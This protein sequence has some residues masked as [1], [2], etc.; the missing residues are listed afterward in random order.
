MKHASIN[1]VSLDDTRFHIAIREI[2]VNVGD[3][4]VGYHITGSR[5]GPTLL[6]AGHGNAMQRVYR[7]IL[8]LPHLP[9]IRGS[10]VLVH[11]DDAKPW[12][13]DSTLDDVSAQFGPIDDT[14]HLF[15]SATDHQELYWT[16]LRFCTQYGMISGR[17]VP[18]RDPA[19]RLVATGPNSEH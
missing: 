15:G 18:M 13:D 11:L 1:P 8:A 12:L 19:L 6:V 14:L 10:L 9:W 17:G 4:S 5:R 3:Q 16:V 7:R 2:D